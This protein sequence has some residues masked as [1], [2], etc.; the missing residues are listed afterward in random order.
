MAWHTKKLTIGKPEHIAYA[1]LLLLGE[2]YH[3]TISKRYLFRTLLPF[4]IELLILFSL[5]NKFI[6][7]YVILPN[8]ILYGVF[9]F[10]LYGIWKQCNISPA[11]Y[12]V[13]QIVI[14][15]VLY[16]LSIPFGYLLEVLWIFCF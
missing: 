5:S 15:T 11:A 10:M 9:V 3:I 8:L 13:F 2:K 7:G 16:L 12:I 4:W 14:I 1:E 6:F